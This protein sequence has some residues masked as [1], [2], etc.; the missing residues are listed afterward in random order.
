MKQEYKLSNGGSNRIPKNAKILGIR[1]DKLGIHISAEVDPSN[2]IETRYFFV[3]IGDSVKMKSNLK[4]ILT[5]DLLVH[6][7]V[8]ILTGELFE[9]K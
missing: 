4:Y 6:D 3:I 9:L 5:Q 1:M 2:E 8:T 7:G